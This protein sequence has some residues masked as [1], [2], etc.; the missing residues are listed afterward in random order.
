MMMSSVTGTGSGDRQIHWPLALAV[1][2]A[3]VQLMASMLM[4]EPATAVPVISV[5]PLATGFMVG[6]TD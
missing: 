3:F 6:L 4:A 1:T 2:G 5:A